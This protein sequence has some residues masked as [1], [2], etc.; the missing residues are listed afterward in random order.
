[1]FGMTM[2]F[3][4]AGLT[5]TY[6]QI[7]GISYLDMQLML[8]APAGRATLAGPGR[9]SIQGIASARVTRRQRA[10]RRVGEEGDDGHAVQEPAPLAAGRPRDEVAGDPEEE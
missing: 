7:M 3:A 4:A 10:V 8:V 1:M 5:Q 6:P 2:A 9:R